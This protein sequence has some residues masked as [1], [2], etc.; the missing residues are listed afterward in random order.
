[1]SS[2]LDRAINSSIRKNFVTFLIIVCCLLATIV[3]MLAYRVTSKFQEA[4]HLNFDHV[5][6]NELYSVDKALQAEMLLAVELSISR[7]DDVKLLGKFEDAV[8]RT[9]KLYIRSL[10]SIEQTDTNRQFANFDKQIEKYKEAYNNLQNFRSSVL[11]LR[12][13][14]KI[15]DIISHYQEMSSKLDVI[16]LHIFHPHNLEH[17]AI[18]QDLIFTKN[19]QKIRNLVAQEGALLLP[20]IVGKKEIDSHTI[21]RLNLIAEEI[22][23]ID[24]IIFNTNL[25]YQ[26][27]KGLYLPPQYRVKL[28]NAVISYK[29]AMDDY[30]DLRD[31]LYLSTTSNLNYKVS[32][33]EW[34]KTL[35]RALQKIN[36]LSTIA[37]EPTQIALYRLSVQETIW[38][39]SVFMIA[40][41]G[42]SILFLLYQIQRKRVFRPIRQLTNAM[43]SLAEGDLNV[44]LPA[45]G[46]DEIGRMINS[47][48][49]FRD[50]AIKR[51]QAEQASLAK[52]EFLANMSHELRTPL[53]SIIGMTQLIK[54]QQL[55]EDAQDAFNSIK[56]SSQSLLNIVNDIL[57]LS[58]IE[59]RQIILEYTPFNL[60]EVV[61]NCT[62]AL[63]PMASKKGLSLDYACPEDLWIM[64][65]SLRFSRIFTNLI[66][67]AIRFTE[68]GFITITVRARE[69]AEENRRLIRA[70]VSDTGIGIA[71]T[72]L[73]T[74]FDKFTQ[75]DSSTTRKY[76][77][78]GLGL[79]I[80]KE[81]VEIM[82]G[83]IGVYSAENKGSIFW[84]EVECDLASP[85]TITDY[86]KQVEMDK[87]SLNNLIPHNKVRVLVAEDQD[88]NQIFMKKLLHNLDIENFTIVENGELAVDHAITGKYDLILMDCHM[89]VMNGY[90]ATTTIR[91][92][93]DE[94][95][96]N[97]PIIA[98]TADAMPETEGK[99][100]AA[101]MNV[102]VSKPFNVNTF[103][104]ILSQW[105]D[106]PDN[107]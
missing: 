23:K 91:A 31:K 7:D 86:A 88:M 13:S 65:D 84:F 49:T 81:L 44:T 55:P 19:I 21:V 102:Y 8:Y 80:T 103:Q 38:L 12:E 36:L 22:N 53:N 105:I 30:I 69:L 75:A 1:M 77:G 10:H 67:N 73:S 85:T 61:H 9:N 64:G 63:K 29:Q 98:M 54:S 42:V 78:T 46:D 74:I 66:S 4:D 40:L 34:T 68:K 99:C 104:K 71:L 107:I 94:K 60:H 33:D 93:L 79:S 90:V 52:S 56:T 39:V 2:K 5:I 27:I 51:E 100:I 16:R 6:M 17:F 26:N 32:P 20:S 95:V 70:E 58:K 83:R 24:Q 14:R 15:E 3:G 57:D 35:N 72:K 92:L 47:L 59:A 37:S 48:K 62:Q 43:T 45:E 87:K 18:Q 41:L 97:I 106:F 28:S 89:P 96:K 25:S 76:G 82:G 101:G 50:T 11:N